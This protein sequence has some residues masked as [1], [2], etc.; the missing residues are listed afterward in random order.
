MVGIVAPSCPVFEPGKLDFAYKWLGKL[1]LR[2]K[3]GKHIFDS[4]SDYAG[5]DED[6]LSDFHDM[7]ADP[8]VSAIIPVRGGNGAVRL[9][10]GLDF[11][12]I[13]RNPKLVIGYSDL[14]GLIVPIHQQT[15]LVT[16]HG[17]ML[18][19]FFESSYTYRNFL[20]ATMEAKP[21]GLIT[22]PAQ[23]EIWNPPYPPARM[24]IAAGKA[25]GRL[26]GGCMTLIR[27]LMGTAYELDTFRR[28]VFLEDL[29]EEP[30]NVDRFLTQLL[31]A[32]KLQ[33]AAGILIG[34]C[35]NCTPGD[36]GRNTMTNNHS[37]ET[38]LRERLGN[39]GIPVVFGL[40]FGH[41]IDKFTL[42]L[43][44]VASLD[45]GPRGVTFKIEESATQ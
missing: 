3:V 21:L 32:G 19:S 20:K 1:G 31:Q 39:L 8:E 12:L 26:T 27:Q 35:I 25:R 43:G 10:P 37:L 40:K 18:G 24:V 38:V 15:G 9:L 30:H 6:R 33:Q 13:A 22:D 11:E 23:K 2:Y 45:A 5:R 44:V 16:F 4:Y 14:T 17:P 36:S 42:P 29:N 28:I 7:W 34:D 41:A